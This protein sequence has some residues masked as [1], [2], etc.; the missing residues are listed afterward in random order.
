MQL[1]ALVRSA[2]HSPTA[3]RAGHF[4]KV[5]EDPSR[6]LLPFVSR[7]PTRTVRL[8][9]ARPVTRDSVAL[10]ADVAPPVACAHG[11]P[12]RVTEPSTTGSSL[13]TRR[14]RPTLSMAF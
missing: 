4:Q 2:T 13:S 6:R 5:P 9:V 1:R 8:V 10:V 7:P 11:A 3:L 14:R 12:V